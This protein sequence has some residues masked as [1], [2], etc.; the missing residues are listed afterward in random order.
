MCQLLDNLHYSVN[1]CFPNDITKSIKEPFKE[2]DR[3][4]DI[5][6]SQSNI[7]VVLDS[8]LQLTLK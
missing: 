2:Q 1:Y 8:T 7:D 4:M 6:I 5:L 3:L